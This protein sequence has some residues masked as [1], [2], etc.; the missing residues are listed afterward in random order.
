VESL[1]THAANTIQHR[2]LT[3]TGKIKF[4][5]ENWI[6]YYNDQN[7]AIRA[8]GTC[9]DITERKLAAEELVKSEEKWKSLVFNSPD[10]IALHDREGRYLFINRSAEG[11]SE[12]DVLG[13][14]SFDNISPESREIFRAAFK[15][16]IRE[17][18][19]QEIKYKAMGNNRE[20]RIYESSLVPFLVKDNEINVLVVARDITERMK[21]DE[22]IRKSREQ[23]AQLHKHLNEVREEERTSIAREI[24]D[25]LG[26]SLAGLKIDLLGIQE[27]IN[28]EICRTQ[29]IEKAISLVETTIKTVQKISSQLRPQMLDELGL[30]SAIEWQASEFKKRTGINCKLKLDE[31]DGLAGNIAISLFR[32]FQAALT[33]IMRHSKATS[34]SVKLETKDQI[35]LLQVIDN[36]I[37]IT[38]E[39][40][41]S[42]KSFGII[43]MLERANQINGKLRI[44]TGVNIGTEIIVSVPLV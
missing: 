2:I 25:D 20:T 37:G 8:L 33:N 11:F 28:D 3:P 23:L 39:Q 30:A 12:K 43:G 5:E 1:N 22:E 36:G 40:L 19:K 41:Y 32:I 34:V 16:C 7:Q 31:I 6:I 21:A 27:D 44:K 15:K 14:V 26:Q 35:I 24:H 29:P 18:T 38:H 9:S 17:M 4:V 10:F 42:A 13:K